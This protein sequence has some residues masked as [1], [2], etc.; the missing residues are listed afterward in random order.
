MQNAGVCHVVILGAAGY[1]G[2]AC[3]RA[4][5]RRAD[6]YRL[7]TL[8]RKS[9][10][11]EPA[12]N[13]IVGDIRQFEPGWLPREPHV[14]VHLA[15]KQLDSD[16]SGYEDINVNGTQRIMQN[17][18]EF[19]R[20]V[21]Y[22]SSMSVYG[23]DEQENIDE[24]AECIPTTA[25]SRSR[26]AAEQAVLNGAKARN[27]SAAV[28]RPR[29]VIGQGDQF[30]LPKLKSLA[31]RKITLNDGRPQYSIIH[32]DDYAEIILALVRVIQP[33]TAE[34]VQQAFN[35]GYRKPISLQEI[36]FSLSAM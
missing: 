24:D 10:E 15:V 5:Q 22:N 7:T 20:G 26:F 19:T 9:Q 35:I 27:I 21:I 1:V 12:P 3:V 16:N 2:R 29:F 4:I 31:Q 33:E 18:N 17:L 11:S 34:V 23:Q 6:E 13:L 14:I 30:V 28:L 36:L 8:V 25:L 32:V